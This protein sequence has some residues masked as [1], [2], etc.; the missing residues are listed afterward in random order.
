MNDRKVG[1]PGTAPRPLLSVVVVR[2]GETTAGSLF[3][4][5]VPGDWLADDRV[6]WLAVGRFDHDQVTQD[7]K[8]WVVVDAES[9][10]SA[11]AARAIGL[12]KARGECVAFLES[13]SELSEAWLPAMLWAAG[14]RREDVTP[15]A[16]SGP[17]LAASRLD[18]VTWSVFFCE[19]VG[20][21]ASLFPAGRLAGNNLLIGTAA[22]RLL[23]DEQ[24]V[25]E[26]WLAAAIARRG[27]GLEA[28]AAAIVRFRGPCSLRVEVSQRLRLGVEFGRMRLASSGWRNSRWL[29]LAAGP[30][31]WLAQ[32]GR[33]LRGVTRAR[34]G[35][36]GPFVACWPMVLAMLMA[37]SVGEWLG[38]S[39]LS[40]ASG[41]RKSRES[42]Q[43]RARGFAPRST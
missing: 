33:V 3:N 2:R 39:G 27:G 7:L 17:V 30:A 13:T 37:W 6:E 5:L 16:G 40:R 26:W 42:D 14:R 8:R 29:G 36:L 11:S 32:A 28:L 31:I 18:W 19:Y 41:W 34:Q 43:A 35:Y 24:P 38:W 12:S 22:R 1:Q 9:G 23:A 10:L 25:E 15:W 20:F 4:N 21:S